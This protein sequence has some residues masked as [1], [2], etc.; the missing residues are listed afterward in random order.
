MNIVGTLVKLPRVSLLLHG[1]HPY[2]DN[3]YTQ[4]YV[5]EDQLNLNIALSSGSFSVRDVFTDGREQTAV[6][7]VCTLCDCADNVI[8]GSGSTE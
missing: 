5:I 2:R 4:Q 8:A 6:F 3:N 7:E 1:G